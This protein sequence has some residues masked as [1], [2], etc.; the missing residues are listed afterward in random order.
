VPAVPSLRRFAF[1][2]NFDMLIPAEPE[3]VMCHLPEDAL[4]VDPTGSE[5]PSDS[6]R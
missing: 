2:K 5:L 1:A 6:V 3:T 4:V